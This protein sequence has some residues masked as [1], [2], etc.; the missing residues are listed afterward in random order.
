MMMTGSQPSMATSITGA[1]ATFPY[2]LYAKWAEKYRALSGGMELNYQSIGSG[3]G[4]KQVI[5]KTVDF[6]AS[7]KPL[8]M[9]E[10][11]SSADSLKKHK[12]IQFPA[13]IGGVVVVYNLP[14]INGKS[15]QLTGKVLSEIYLGKITKWNDEKLKKL[16]PDIT[17]PDLSITVIHRSDG[18]G[19]TYLFTSYLSNM[20]E[21]W[22]KV[23]SDTAIAWPAGIGAKGNE[24]V[25]ANVQ[26]T[27]GGIGYVEYSYAKPNKLSLCQLETAPGVFIP[28]TV[29]SFQD[30]ALEAHWNSEDGFYTTMTKA[31]GSTGWPI[32]GASYILIQQKVDGD[33]QA[34]VVQTLKFFEWAFSDEGQKIA[35]ELDY[36][37]LPGSLVAKIK[38]SWSQVKDTQ[39]KS[40]WPP[41]DKK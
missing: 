32:T 3:G 16:N 33:K 38:D 21:D 24:G 1:G 7:D 18:S 8:R 14:T 9:T 29:D 11:S 39:G 4:I 15:L 23:G 13:I 30:A 25:A 17:L 5:A 37:P 20:S 28:P 22:Q 27:V 40:L 34:N 2:P 19:T 36:V 41:V 35:K 10:S 31:S 26:S 6:G 12:L